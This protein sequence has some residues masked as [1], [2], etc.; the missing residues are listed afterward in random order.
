MRLMWYS[1]EVIYTAGK[2]LTT[3]DALSHAPVGSPQETDLLLESDATALVQSVIDGIPA[4]QGRLVEIRTKQQQHWV[5]SQVAR[6][7]RDGWPA[8]KSKLH[9]DV[10][11]FYMARDDLT[12]QDGLLLYRTRLVIPVE[13][14]KDILT[15]IHDG[16]Q[17]IVKCRALAKCS[18]WWAG[19]SQKIQSLIENCAICEKERKA[20]P[21]PLKPSS[22]L[23]FPWQKVGMDLFHWRGKQYLLVVDYFS[24]N[25]ELAYL[26]AST[27]SETVIVHCKSIF[28]RHGI[29]EVVQSDNG[30]QFASQKFSRFATE[31]GFTNET[32]SP[33]YPQANGEA[34]RAV[35][36]VKNFLLKAEDPY[37]ALL[38]Y[39]VTPLQCSFSPAEMSMGRCLRTRV[40]VVPALLTPDWPKLAD[41]KLA[42][43]NQ[44]EVQKKNF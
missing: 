36:M 5:C 17:G 26:Q 11:P 40:P 10:C 2:N 30:P 3:A 14:R 37:L 13:L 18:V 22:V 9:P 39:R 29:P 4:S 20:R 25:T 6:Y 1:Y 12:V 27:S 7:C 19:L 23:D 31:Y 24:R 33:H 43:A 42:N 34:E 15:R 38:N 21:E 44:K 16:H 41:M 32:S 28:A 8:V 35:Q